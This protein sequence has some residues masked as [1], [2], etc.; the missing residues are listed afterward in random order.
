MNFSAKL[1]F[2]MT[3][4]KTTNSALSLYTSLDASHISRLRRG[5][6]SLSRNET[7]SGRMASYFARNC[8]RDYQRNALFDA[9]RIQSFPCD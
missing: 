4:T 8:S 3:I 9:L 5:Q 2:L 1:D 6:R 7:Y